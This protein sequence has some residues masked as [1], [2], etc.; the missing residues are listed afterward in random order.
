[1]LAVLNVALPCVIA[2]GTLATNPKSPLLTLRLIPSV[3]LLLSKLLAD[4]IMLSPTFT[5]VIPNI[6]LPNSVTSS[7]S[8]LSKL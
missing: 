8:A 1:M 5:L 7:V 4:V 3:A 6:A 2:T